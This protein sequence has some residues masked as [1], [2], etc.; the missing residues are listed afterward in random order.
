MSMATRPLTNAQWPCLQPYLR[1]CPGIYVG[2]AVRSR[3]LVEAVVW[4]ARAGAPWHQWPAKYGQWNSVYRRY[5]AWCNRGLWARLMHPRRLT[6]ICPP[7]G[8]TA[9]LCART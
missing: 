5:A 3:F 9:R 6:Q 2:H 7:C 4:I 8:W 1:A